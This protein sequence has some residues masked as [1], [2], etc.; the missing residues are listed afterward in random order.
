MR[1]LSA[2]NIL[3]GTSFGCTAHAIIDTSGVGKVTSIEVCL[4]NRM[5]ARA[6]H[7]GA[8]CQVRTVGRVTSQS[9]DVRIELR[10]VV[11]CHAAVIGRYDCVSIKIAD[12]AVD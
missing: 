10:T 12:L 2:R 5:R 8:W 3:A 11:T 9:A 6:G 7:A 4:N 1:G